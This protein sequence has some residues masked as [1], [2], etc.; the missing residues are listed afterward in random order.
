MMLLKRAILP[1]AAGLLLLGGCTFFDGS[2]GE[3]SDGR[4]ADRDREL[5]VIHSL[6]ETISSVELTSDGSLG[7]VQNDVQTLGAVPNQILR[8][9]EELIV[10]LSGQNELLRLDESTLRVTGRINHGAGSNPMETTPLVPG[11]TSNDAAAGLLVTTHLLAARVQIDDLQD[12]SWD[13]PPP[14]T[15]DVGQ[16]PQALISLPGSS[17]DQVRLLVANTNFST[18]SAA[19]SPFGR[20]TLSSMVFELPGTGSAGAVERVDKETIDLEPAD[21]DPE[22]DSGTNPTALI[23]A[24]SLGEV[25]VVGS[26][27][28]YGAEGTGEDDGVLVTLNRDTLTVQERHNVGGSPGAAVLLPEGTGHR[29]YLGGP[30]GIRSLKHDGTEWA[31][32]ARREYDA[33]GNGDSLPFIADLARYENTIY[34]ADFANNR[35]LAFAV[36]DNGVL[37][38]R[39]EM[40]LSEGPIALLIDLE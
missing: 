9:G 6:A 33:T 7:D 37:S 19:P 38:L 21:F 11:A 20:A 24:P 3:A 22:H 2:G 31:A 14:W 32:E 27:I 16:A 35:I 5:F 1:A 15:H 18:D 13:P 12:R 4:S 10:T 34:A 23:D 17:P 29:L 26:G 8:V 28:N 39:E 36:G 25:L 40:R 30:T